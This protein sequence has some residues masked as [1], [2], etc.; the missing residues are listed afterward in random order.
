MNSSK[1]RCKYALFAIKIFILAPYLLPGNP[2]SFLNRVVSK[3]VRWPVA[4]ARENC[5]FWREFYL[6]RWTMMWS[7]DPP[8]ICTCREFFIKN[9]CL[10][11]EIPTL[12]IVF[13]INWNTISK[14]N[15]FECFLQRNV[16]FF[17]SFLLK[18]EKIARNFLGHNNCSADLIR[19][20]PVHHKKYRG[21]M[22]LGGFS[23]GG[24][25]ISV[26]VI[27]FFFFKN[28]HPENFLFNI[29]CKSACENSKKRRSNT[30]R[31]KNGLKNFV[32]T[33]MC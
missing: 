33:Q 2:Y 20:S 21:H 8:G 6:I 28:S 5:L 26:V 12:C 29:L 15:S 25:P 32:N 9:S 23:R 30:E 16:K 3:A 27:F 11:D 22:L 24:W 31:G 13:V 10:R 7:R 14:P 4:A 1:S 17:H 18:T 19:N